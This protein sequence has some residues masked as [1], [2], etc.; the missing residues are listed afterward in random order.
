MRLPLSGL[1]ALIES[2]GADQRV[3]TDPTPNLLRKH[4][5]GETVF[6][7]FE[8]GAAEGEAGVGGVDAITA[9]QERGKVA[10]L[11]GLL[12][13]GGGRPWVDLEDPEAVATQASGG[14]DGGGSG[15]GHG[16]L[17]PGW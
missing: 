12:G 5:G 2:Q 1:I 7:D 8:G 10:R 9:E 4:P 11:A 3:V 14:F 16:R 13:D 15:A 6:A 17:L